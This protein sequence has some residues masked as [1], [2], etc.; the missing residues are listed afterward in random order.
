MLE[1]VSEIARP[2]AYVLHEAIRL[3]GDEELRRHWGA[4]FISAFSA[5]LSIA[6]SLIV[7]VC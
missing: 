1:T 4:L 7:P 6:L 2:D 3:G 5:G